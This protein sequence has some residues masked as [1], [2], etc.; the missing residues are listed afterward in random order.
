MI[1]G[2]N[3]IAIELAELLAGLGRRVQV[4]ERSGRLA[5]PAGKKRR[6]DHG[7]QLD[8]LG[9]P[10]NTG[11]NLLAVETGGVR[12]ALERG[13]ERVIAADTV[14]VVGHPHEDGRML[15]AMQGAAP[16]VRSIGDASGFGL[17]KKAVGE[18]LAA[19]WG[20]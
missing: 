11:V 13:G 4:L 1:I 12:I 19:G 14:I 2:A 20:V 8:R 16:V 10:V 15:E 5:M 9:V 7:K 18:A 3:L 17:S 6:G